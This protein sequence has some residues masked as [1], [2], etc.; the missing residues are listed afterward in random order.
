MST[1]K[2]MSRNPAGRIIKEDILRGFYH[3]RYRFLLVVIVI[4]GVVVL[5][6][7]RRHSMTDIILFLQG[8]CEY[9]D[10][11]RNGR[12]E[13]PYI[14]LLMQFMPAFLVFNYCNDD[15]EGVGVDVLIKCQSRVLWWFSKCIWN[16]C[17]VIVFYIIT[18]FITFIKALG[19]GKT[20]IKVNAVVIYLMAVPVLVSIAAGL[21]Q[22]AVSS[23]FNP[24]IGLLAVMLL[25]AS[26]VFFNT[27][28]LIGNVSM[29]MRSSVYS[30]QGIAVWKGISTCVL[31]YV[32]SFIAGMIVFK[33]KDILHRESGD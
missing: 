17:T 6:T 26:S 28:L 3:N 7:G 14:W 11:L 15:C 19:N 2:K 33:K 16:V 25:M 30:A 32:I 24:V 31:M 13:F 4:T 22:M 23:A 12:I 8:G 18:Y 29:V 5:M 20:D 9:S 1:K 10:M 21:F 27:P